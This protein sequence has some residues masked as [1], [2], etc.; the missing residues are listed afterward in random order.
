[1]SS[2]DPRGSGIIDDMLHAA[3]IDFVKVEPGGTVL[4]AELANL[5]GSPLPTETMVCPPGSPL[6]QL[7]WW[8]E[9]LCQARRYWIGR[10]QGADSALAKFRGTTGGSST[11][12]E[13]A[14]G[15]TPE[16]GREHG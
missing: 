6:E 14:D 12:P 11:T 3:R 5:V 13:P 9:Q 4:V 1:M 2:S 10:A 16:Q 7:R 8:L 15:G